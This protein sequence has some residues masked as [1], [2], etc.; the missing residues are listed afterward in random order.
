MPGM[1]AIIREFSDDCACVCPCSGGRLVCACCGTCSCSCASSARA[2]SRS[3]RCLL[4]EANF[5]YLENRF[6]ALPYNDLLAWLFG[7]GG[8]SPSM[9]NS[10]GSAPAALRR[11]RPCAVLLPLMVAL[12]SSES[13]VS[14]ARKSRFKV[15]N[16]NLHVPLPDNPIANLTVSAYRTRA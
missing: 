12:L 11:D 7:W 2:R 3:C 1:A 15:K 16:V 10:P 6:A 14:R 8:D 9:P 5:R 13:I 4:P